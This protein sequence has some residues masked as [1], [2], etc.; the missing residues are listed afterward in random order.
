[1]I[2]VCRRLD[3]LPLAIELAAARLRSLS[4]AQLESRLDD[5][6]RLLTGRRHAEVPRQQTLQAV[7]AWSYD[8]LDD[9]EKLV[10]SRM[11]VF[12]DH[13]TLEMAEA[14]GSA[15]PVDSGTSSISSRASSTNRW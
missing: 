15:P 7:V 1:M 4:L 12:P 11:A 13:F 6:F 9:V 8:L 2:Q 10:F 14:V 5:R 3:G